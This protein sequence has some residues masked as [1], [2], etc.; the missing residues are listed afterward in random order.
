MKQQ[1]KT[2]SFSPADYAHAAGLPAVLLPWYERCKRE[3]P[4][5]GAKDAYA[6]W[7]SEIMLQ[8]TRVE[9]VR[10]YFT[11]FLAVLPT[12]RALAEC[13]EDE[14]MKL[15]QG[16]GYYNR[17]RNLQRAARIIT[18]QYGGAL[19]RSYE[20]LAALPGIGDYTAGA[21]ASIA[22]GLPVPCVDGN[23]LRVLSRV[24]ADARDVSRPPMKAA[25]RALAQLL[26]P[27][28]RAGD[29]NQSLMELGATVCLPNGAP[30]CGECPAAALCRACTA[31]TQSAFPVK[32][33][34]AVRRV[35]KRTVLLAV[36]G[37]RVLLLRRPEK[38][39]L[40]GLWEFPSTEGWLS[41]AEA[42]LFA[43]R[44]GEAAAKAVLL[45]GAKHIFTHLEWQMRGYA[46][47][48]SG[49]LP[50]QNGVWATPDELEKQYALP[51][52]LA[53]YAAHVGEVC[54]G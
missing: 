36:E 16:L 12:P 31:Q 33:P 5:R 32:P 1:T 37:K 22:Y 54:M 49:P 19:P 23:V 2:E 7:V 46:V 24:L 44:Y 18:E 21:V 3:M 35:E 4:W 39:L 17:A 6:V 25:Y 38:G 48:L 43:A 26:I 52:A 42:R 40:A 28:G 47:R 15:W 51:S 34:K 45:G 27:A 30:L 50:V 9:A 29:F 8:Q 14:L 13:P 41:P 11:R 20:E 10:G 53:A